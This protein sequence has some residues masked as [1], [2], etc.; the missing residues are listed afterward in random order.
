MNERQK[1]SK[2]GITLIALIV[3]IVVLLILAGTSIAMLTGENGIINQAELSKENTH[4]GQLKE[5]L[6]II[7]NDLQIEKK[8]IG[9][10]LKKKDIANKL[11]EI[12]KIINYT[13]DMISGEYKNNTFIVD[14]NNRV[15]IGDASIGEKPT[16]KFI[17]ST[18]ENG[19]ESIELQVIGSIVDGEIKSIESLDGLI[20]K[21]GGSKSS[22]TYII[23][24]N[25]EYSFKIVASSGRYSIEKVVVSNIMQEMESESL[26]TGIS[27]ITASGLNRITVSG[28]TDEGNETTEKYEL[29]VIHFDNNLTIGDTLKLNGEEVTNE[30]LNVEEG[31][32]IAGDSDDAGKRTVVLKINGNLTIEEGKTLTSVV[33]ANKGPK[34]MIVYCTGI[35]DNNGT[36]SMSSC[37]LSTNGENV[38]LYKKKDN[39]FVYV[40][41]FGGIGG[42]KAV[43]D[44]ATS[45]SA[46][47]S[48]LGCGRRRTVLV[49]ITMETI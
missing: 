8:K 28:K 40:P 47:E 9:E 44:R 27:E 19:V 29:D 18:K 36:I 12:A 25:K 11:S 5:E 48:I 20:P 31:T 21:S 14:E 2:K 41:Q 15:I 22:Q 32:W 34:G 42:K 7:I 10:E 43:R 49:I 16:A 37:G 38:Y 17:K 1:K 13:E 33:S 39:S 24:R 46:S 3:T 45:G 26:L 6:E 35:L 4:K 23:T 30:K